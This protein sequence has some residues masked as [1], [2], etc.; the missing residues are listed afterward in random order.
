MSDIFDWLK[1]F[2]I[3]DGSYYKKIKESRISKY[4]T[5][6]IK[7]TS[8]DSDEEASVEEAADEKC[9]NQCSNDIE[10]RL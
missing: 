5:D 7:F 6:D 4:I 8:G 3:K 9:I 10:V 2:I 1:S